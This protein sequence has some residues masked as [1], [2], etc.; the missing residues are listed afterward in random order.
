MRGRARH[1]QSGPSPASLCQLLSGAHNQFDNG[2]SD[3]TSCSP[4]GG[5]L[6]T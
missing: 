1:Y 2:E 5:W 4:D 3:V 6:S